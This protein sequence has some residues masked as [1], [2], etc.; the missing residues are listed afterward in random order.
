MVSNEQKAVIV[1]GTAAFTHFLGFLFHMLWFKKG[2]DGEAGTYAGMVQNGVLPDPGL[3]VSY[4]LVQMIIW[5]INAL[6][7]IPAVIDGGNPPFVKV[8]M[9]LFTVAY[10]L[11][12]FAAMM[13]KEQVT[14]IDDGKAP[15]LD[16]YATS[17]QMYGFGATLF[18]IGLSI[19][20]FKIMVPAGVNTFTAALMFLYFGTLNFMI[21]AFVGSSK[22]QAIFDQKT[23]GDDYPPVA[24]TEY[25]FAN[26][27]AAFT[28]GMSLL[29]YDSYSA[30]KGAAAKEGQDYSA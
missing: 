2:I 19:L 26:G 3:L 8:S 7:R 5:P 11:L 28:I 30:M 20:K 9:A 16:K 21:C 18:L 24:W 6:V 29:A 1:N 10:L 13:W 14:L 15:E 27:H 22:L 23:S 25:D 17:F 12:T 4:C